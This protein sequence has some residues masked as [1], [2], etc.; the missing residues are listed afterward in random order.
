[1]ALRQHEI[2]A[3]YHF[4]PARIG[5]SVA[6]QREAVQDVRNLDEK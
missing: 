4:I 6:K 1:M 2:L 5:Y 3:I